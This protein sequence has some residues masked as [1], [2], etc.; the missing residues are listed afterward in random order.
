MNDLAERKFMGMLEASGAPKKASYNRAEFCRIFG[1]SERTFYRMVAAHDLDPETG[2]PLFPWT[3]DS[4]M[5]RGHHRVRYAECVDYLARNRT[6]ERKLA[7]D[8]RQ[9]SIFD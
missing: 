2:E 5:T 4:Y 6:I 8:P 1:I 7:A 3:V 9:M